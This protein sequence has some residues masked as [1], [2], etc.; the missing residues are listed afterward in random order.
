MCL[1]SLVTQIKANQINVLKMS[2]YLHLL[3]IVNL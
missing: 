3:A 1:L 2:K